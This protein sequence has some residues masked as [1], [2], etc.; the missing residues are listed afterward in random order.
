ML[1]K[2]LKAPLTMVK[3]RNSLAFFKGAEATCG[4]IVT[5]IKKCS[6]LKDMPNFN[7]FWNFQPINMF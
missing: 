4:E 3:P 5:A 6:R 1:D 7:V 2:V